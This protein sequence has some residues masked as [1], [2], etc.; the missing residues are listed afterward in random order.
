MAAQ[1]EREALTGVSGVERPSF[2]NR[3]ADLCSRQLGSRTTTE[4]SRTGGWNLDRYTTKNP[5]SALAGTLGVI[6]HSRAVISRAGVERLSG[7]K[8]RYSDQLE[9]AFGTCYSLVR[10]R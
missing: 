1:I 5:G 4:P 3:D 7:P 8:H 6:Q 2:E 10:S 9:V